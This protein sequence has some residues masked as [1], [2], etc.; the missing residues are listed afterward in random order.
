MVDGR[1][2]IG[3]ARSTTL[4][5]GELRGKYKTFGLDSLK[6]IKRVQTLH[7]PNIRRFADVVGGGYNPKRGVLILLVQRMDLKTGR[8]I[9]RNT[10]KA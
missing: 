10:L 3:L 4:T 7:A 9:G 6:P 5:N 1:L 2:R 8:P